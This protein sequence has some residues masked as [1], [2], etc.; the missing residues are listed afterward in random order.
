MDQMAQAVLHVTRLDGI[1]APG[2]EI[3]LPEGAP[4]YGWVTLFA[5]IGLLV[6]LSIIS[7][8]IISTVKKAGRTEATVNSVHEQVANTHKTN[9]REDIDALQKAITEGLAPIA[10]IQRTVQ[11]VE[12]KV[13]VTATAVDFLSDDARQMRKDVADLRADRRSDSEKVDRMGEQ[14]TEHLSREK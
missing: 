8:V 3:T 1:S 12:M 7:P 2:V 11:R 6:G 13:E 4:W 5:S 9:L 10:E 14:F